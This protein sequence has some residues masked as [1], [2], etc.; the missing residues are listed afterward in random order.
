MADR[1]E[2]V[3][4]SNWQEFVESDTAVLMLGR[5]DCDA[6]VMY[7]D[8]LLEFLAEDDEWTDVRFGKMLLDQPGLASFKQKAG[9]LSEVSD[10]PYTAIYSNGELEKTFAGNG[11]DRLTNRLERLE[12]DSGGGLYK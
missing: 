12:S 8:E 2:E 1:L 4:G 11:V 9:W 10:L 6:C 7:T 3:D 5:T